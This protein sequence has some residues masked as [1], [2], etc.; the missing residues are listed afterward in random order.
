VRHMGTS[1]QDR[2]TVDMMLEDLETWAIVGLSGDPGRTVYG[3][4]AAL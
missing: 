1:W 4:A 2:E 3:V